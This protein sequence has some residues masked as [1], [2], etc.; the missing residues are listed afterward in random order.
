[1]S[2]DPGGASGA[3]AAPHSRNATREA[4]IEASLEIIAT[5]GLDQ[6]SVRQIAVRT[7]YSA[8]AIAYHVTPMSRFVSELWV[9]IHRSVVDPILISA[10]AAYTARNDPNDWGKVAADRWLDW[11]ERSPGLARF[12]VG[13]TP[14]PAQVSL[15]H[16][17]SGVTA[18]EW[19][20]AGDD[21][22]NTWWYFVRRAQAALEL[23]LRSGADPDRDARLAGQLTEIVR[24]WDDTRNEILVGA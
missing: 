24:Q 21:L 3:D 11:A 12:Y 2:N 7:F 16:Q 1:M 17:H 10:R 20:R 22:R 5:S 23:A 6:L 15:T 14:D 13:F 19:A 18:E 9:T 4:I 8:S